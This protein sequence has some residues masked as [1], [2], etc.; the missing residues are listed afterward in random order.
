MAASI[1]PSTTRKQQVIDL[2]K[3]IESGAPGPVAVI[4]PKKYIQHNL[5]AADGLAGF[6]ELLKQ[7]P[8]GSAKVNTRRVLQD[9]DFV[10]AHTEYDFFGPKIGFDIFRFEGRPRSSSTGT[11]F[12]R[13]RRRTASGRTM[14]DGPTEID[15]SRPDRRRTRRSFGTSSTTSSSTAVWRRSTG[16]FDG[17]NVHAAQSRSSATAL[18]GLGTPRV[19]WPR[20]A[21][22]EVRARPRGARR[23][24]LRAR[25]QRRHVRAA[26]P[27]RSTTCSASRTARSPSTGTPSKRFRPVRNGRTRMASS[28]SRQVPVPDEPP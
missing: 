15:R 16:Y 12:R 6:G 2:L 26:S 7:L 10:F 4:N 22:T 3:S 5:A 23:R 18:S 17:D 19:E 24:Q 11:T 21:I 14:I 8:P 1:Q 27:R 9:G 28:A 25:R 20:P 13:R